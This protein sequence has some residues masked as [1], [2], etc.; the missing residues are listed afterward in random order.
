MNNLDRLK[1]GIIDVYR[2]HG[3]RNGYSPAAISHMINDIDFFALYQ[4]LRICGDRKRVYRYVAYYN[5][6]CGYQSD[7]L[8]PG[9]VV[10]LYAITDYR[11]HEGDCE[12]HHKVELVVCEDM[13]L[14]TLI[15]CETCC[16]SKFDKDDYSSEYR[17]VREEWPLSVAAIDLDVLHRRLVSFC[18]GFDEDEYLYIEA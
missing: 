17:E 16:G 18:R 6:Y 8:L 1:K 12:I 5:D 15:C 7:R 9:D 3:E 13:S 10:E 11:S 4:T 2:I 14:T